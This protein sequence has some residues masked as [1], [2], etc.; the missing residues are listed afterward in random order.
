[1]INLAVD[2][3]SKKYPGFNLEQV[4]FNIPEGQV[5]GFIGPNG[6]GKTSTIKIIMGLIKSD[7]GNIEVMGHTVRPEDYKYREHIAFVYDECYYWGTLNPIEIAS[8][9]GKM[10]KRFDY[11]QFKKL[12]KQYELP[13]N[14]HIATY[15]KGMKTK[16]SLAIALARQCEL[17]ILD[18]PT[19]GLDPVVRRI[20]LSELEGYSRNRN[21]SVLFSTHILS[22]VDRIA[23]SAAIIVNGKI[24]IFAPISNLS[25]DYYLITTES[26]SIIE[27]LREYTICVHKENSQTHLLINKHDAAHA[28]EGSASMIH[29][30]LDDILYHLVVA[31]KVDR[32]EEEC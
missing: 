8:I 7:A 4:S 25:D 9:I 23:D 17:L 15:S 31:D 30:N 2:G 19:S 29:A 21:G 3:L 22:D 1:M 5:L 10:S 16:L 11:D 32:E 24:K 20:V 18:E 12:L 26:D 27:K 6:A 14:Q 28:A 13:Q